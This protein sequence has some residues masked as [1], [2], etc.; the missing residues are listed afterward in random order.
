M[1]RRRPPALVVDSLLAIVVALVSLGSVDGP[2]GAGIARAAG[3]LDD[4]PAALQRQGPA[5]SGTRGSS[6]S[7]T[8]EPSVA[9]GKLPPTVE[10]RER[11][12]RGRRRRPPPTAQTGFYR[13]RVVLQRRSPVRA[14]PSCSRATARHPT[15]R[16]RSRSGSCCS[17]CWRRCRSR[18]GAG[19]RSPVLAV[20]LAAALAATYVDDSLRLPRPARRALQRGG[21]RRAAALPVR[22]RGAR[23]PLLVLQ[24]LAIDSLGFW[25][26]LGIYALFGAAWLLGD[27]VRTR[28]ER[29]SAARGRARGQLAAGGGRGAGADRARAARRHRPQ[30]ERDDHPG[31]GRRRRVR[32]P[33]RA[34]ARGAARDR[35]DGPRG[36][37]RAAAPAGRRAAATRPP[38]PPP[39]ASRT[40]T[41]W[42]SACAPPG[43]R[44][45]SS[46][47]AGRR[48]RRASTCRRTGSC[49]RR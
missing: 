47:R 25:E 3:R 21:V 33:A 42:S 34:G 2:V 9:P 28:R 43:W 36:A 35:V 18:S 49:R 45:S 1:A 40:S 27:N 37:G 13:A 38:S 41:R 6:S 19:G 46:G 14:T 39:R 22:G 15:R 16:P 24:V 30:R 23:P 32:Q 44:S 26:L 7:A 48:C 29:A 20:T 4:Q 17:S 31:R 10:L 5:T 11:Q 12:R 8:S